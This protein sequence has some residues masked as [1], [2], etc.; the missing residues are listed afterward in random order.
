MN[1]LVLPP[2]ERIA[3][4]IREVAC[5]VGLAPVTIRERMKNR[6]C[7]FVKPPCNRVLLINGDWELLRPWGANLI[8]ERVAYVPGEDGRATIADMCAERTNLTMGQIQQA[9]GICTK[10]IKRMCKNGEL[11]ASDETGFWLVTRADLVAFLLTHRHSARWEDD[12]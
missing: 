5:I 7:A 12:E 6:T 10:S 11:R 3:L 9:T 1:S 2:I 4:S 8:G